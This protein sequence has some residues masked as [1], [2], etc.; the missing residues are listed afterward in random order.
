MNPITSHIPKSFSERDKCKAFLSKHPEYFINQISQEYPFTKQQLNDF[1]D[2]LDWELVSYNATINWDRE[3]M[4]EFGNVLDW[5]AISGNPSAF[6]DANLLDVFSDRLDWKGNDEYYWDSVANNDG[7][8]WSEDFVKRY[9]SLLNFKKLSNNRVIKWSENLI[10]TYLD[11]LDLETLGGN[12]SVPW[13]LRLFD[14]YLDKGYLKFIVVLINQTLLSDIKFIDKYGSHLNWVYVCSNPNLPWIEKN[15]FNHWNKMIDWY[16]IAHNE[17][18]FE[19]DKGLFLRNMGKWRMDNF[20]GFSALSSNKSLPWSKQFNDTY[21]QNWNW[22][23]ISLNEGIP[24]NIELIDYFADSLVWGRWYDTNII[25]KNGE[26]ISPTGGRECVRGLTNNESLPW[27][28][29]FINYYQQQIDF[30]RLLMNPS[31]WEK[32]F[33]HIINDAFIKDF[34]A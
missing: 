27:S 28:I 23:D 13:N 9:E 21:K 1:G 29:D 25:D 11:R 2:R 24:W 5:K 16:G 33:K 14:K 26:E 22:G 7:L 31:V 32:A 10:D 3:M 12:E 4:V 19:R 20:R 8:P 17:S 18:L 15:L 6:K 30:E 34:F